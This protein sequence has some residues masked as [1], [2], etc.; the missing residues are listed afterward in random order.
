[1]LL[2]ISRKEGQQ[3]DIQDIDRIMVWLMELG[4]SLK[5]SRPSELQE[6][7]KWD[8]P[9]KQFL[10]KTAFISIEDLQKVLFMN[11]VLIIC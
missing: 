5:N 7:A 11:P 9:I 8:E 6:P 10:Y 4:T 1:M 3:D 2:N